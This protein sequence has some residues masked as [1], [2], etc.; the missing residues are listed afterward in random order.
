LTNYRQQT[1]ISLGGLSWAQYAGI[2]SNSTLY[3]YAVGGAVCSNELVERLLPFVNAPSPDVAGYQLPAFIADSNY[4]TPNGTKFFT[5][6]R[7]TTVYAIWIGTNDLGNNAFFT[8]D[9]KKGKTVKDYTD[10]V[11]NTIEKLYLN[12]AQH[13]VL[14][15]LSPLDILPQYAAP[16]DGGLS[17]TQYFPANGRNVTDTHFRMLE[18]V[19]SLNQVYK[20]RTPFEAVVS[21]KYPGIKIVNF[22]VTSLITDIHSNPSKYLNGTAPL[23]VTGV[24]HKCDPQGANCTMADSPDSYMWYDEI[25]PSQ[26][27][28]R[29]VAKEFLSVL[30]GMSRWASYWG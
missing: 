21:S 23:N 18:T 27:T 29:I 15:N 2:Y 4:T 10:C 12:G 22:D 3:N 14:F 1:A 25:H 7:D 19:A 28:S 5:G 26:Q 6:E 20:Y 17:E 8:N 24:V 13:F 30:S 9:Q 16:D 11:Y